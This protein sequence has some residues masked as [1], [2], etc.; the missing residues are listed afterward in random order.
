MKTPEDIRERRAEL[1]ERMKKLNAK[2]D[3]LS[4]KFKHVQD[5]C[6]HPNKYGTDSMGRDP[7][8]A[9]CPDCGKSW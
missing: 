5:E 3:R 9:H 8:G 1:A 2:R 4:L 6:A 7:N